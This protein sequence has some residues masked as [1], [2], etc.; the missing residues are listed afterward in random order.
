MLSGY[1]EAPGEPTGRTLVY[2]FMAEVP[3]PASVA[4]G[5]LEPG[6]AGRR[7]QDHLEALRE[8]ALPA[9]RQWL[10]RQGVPE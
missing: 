8:A 9:A 3:G 6:D 4:P 2:A 1:Y 10:S 5:D 7:L